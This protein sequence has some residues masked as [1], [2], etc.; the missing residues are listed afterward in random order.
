MNN[1]IFYILTLVFFVFASCGDEM[2]DEY[3]QIKKDLE[4]AKSELSEA[5]KAAAKLKEEEKELVIASQKSK[6]DKFVN[7]YFRIYIVRSSKYITSNDFTIK[8]IFEESKLTKTVISYNSCDAISMESY[9]KHLNLKQTLVHTSND[10]G[11]ITKSECDEYTVD[12]IWESSKRLKFILKMKEQVDKRRYEI[13]INENN[14]LLSDEAFYASYGQRSHCYKT[15]CNEAGLITKIEVF[16]SKDELNAG[17]YYKYDSNN[18]IIEH[19]VKEGS[20]EYVYEYSY[21]TEN[22]I[23]RIY[24][25]KSRA[26][27]EIEKTFT[28]KDG[29]VYVKYHN[30]TDDIIENSEYVQE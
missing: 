19:K 16:N 28:Y 30:I 15:E 25:K 27:L 17:Y 1:K 7:W 3:E 11:L 9:Y 24:T 8:N 18:N 29:K 13:V 2:K 22:R 14:Q 23:T 26:G 10:D 20:S 6:I 21:D 5:E 12:W 4:K